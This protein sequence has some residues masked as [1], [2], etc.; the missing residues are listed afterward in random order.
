S[1]PVQ[2]TPLFVAVHAVGEALGIPMRPP[3]RS[4]SVSQGG[5]SL[6]AMV[7]AL[8]LRL[9]RV[10]LTGSWWKHDSGPLLAYTR[11]GHQPVALLPV[12]SGRYT[13]FDPVSRIRTPVHARL[14]ATLASEAYTLYRPFPS[15][16]LR[17]LELLRF[18]LHG[19]GKDLRLALLTGMAVTLLGM[20][21]PQATAML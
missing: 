10:L 3:A 7:Q 9:R 12:A 13:L 8:H 18:G 5:E 2:G 4:V 6:E 20:L 17:G 1:A 21:T 15:C 19:R 11:E 16:A 14:A